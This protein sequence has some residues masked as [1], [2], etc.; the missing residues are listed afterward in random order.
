MESK[1]HQ[2]FKQFLIQT[3]T[4]RSPVGI[5]GP[6]WRPLD[7][8]STGRPHF[9]MEKL[10]EDTPDIVIMEAP[11]FQVGDLVR[12]TDNECSDFGMVG[13]VRQSLRGCKVTHIKVDGESEGMGDEYKNSSYTK[14]TSQGAKMIFLVFKVIKVIKKRNGG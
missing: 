14:K 3:P 4:K 5:P 8:V 7:Y 13:V 10:P 2:K 9:F 1:K 11:P 12:I 6:R